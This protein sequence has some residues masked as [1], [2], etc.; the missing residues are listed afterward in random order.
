[1]DT[2]IGTH[3]GNF[4]VVL[5]ESLCVPSRAEIRIAGIAQR[6]NDN[7]NSFVLHA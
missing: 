7:S 1:M 6:S 2:A 5:V 3:S 4:S